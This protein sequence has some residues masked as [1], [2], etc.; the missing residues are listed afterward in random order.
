M[1]LSGNTSRNHR[2]RLRWSPRST[3][4]GRES[5]KVARHRGWSRLYEYWRALGL[6]TWLHSQF[7]SRLTNLS[8]ISSWPV[9]GSLYSDMAWPSRSSSSRKSARTTVCSFSLACT[10]GEAAPR[11]AH[12]TD[13]HLSMSLLLGWLWQRQSC[14]CICVPLCRWICRVSWS[15]R[16]SPASFHALAPASCDYSSFFAHLHSWRREWAS[17]YVEGWS[18]SGR[19]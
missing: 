13:C 1:S 12:P 19:R 14:G 9:P 7:P 10:S 5:S 15:H 6:C 8:T 2:R 11:R 17:A 16:T 4:Y 3:L 18:G